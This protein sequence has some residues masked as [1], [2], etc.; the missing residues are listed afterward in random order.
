VTS[1]LKVHRSYTYIRIRLYVHDFEKGQKTGV[2][3]L[4]IQ[5]NLSMLHT[6]RIYVFRENVFKIVLS[7]VYNKKQYVITRPDLK[8]FEL[9]SLR[10]DAW[11]ALSSCAAAAAAAST[12]PYP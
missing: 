6:Y 10:C 3:A 4:S 12:L 2:Y 1:V 11:A 8:P 5:L 9:R 7:G